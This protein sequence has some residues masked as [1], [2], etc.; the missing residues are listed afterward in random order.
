MGT[1]KCF[2]GTWSFLGAMALGSS[3]SGPW[4]EGERL[5]D[6]RLPTIDGSRTISLAE[7]RGARLLLVEFASW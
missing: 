5:P 6:L 4:K 2:A 3:Q 7:L 1:M